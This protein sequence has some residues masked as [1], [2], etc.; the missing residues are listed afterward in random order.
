[1]IN[2]PF[3]YHSTPYY[4]W[5][6][7][8]YMYCLEALYAMHQLIITFVMYI[9]NFIITSLMSLFSGQNSEHLS[10]FSNLSIEVVKSSIEV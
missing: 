8:I 5:L 1:M 3:N 10:N 7:A 6:N 2:F 9:F 4:V